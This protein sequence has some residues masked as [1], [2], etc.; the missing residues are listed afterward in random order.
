[1]NGMSHNRVW[2]NL[3]NSTIA[4]DPENLTLKGMQPAPP[5]IYPYHPNLFS[6]LLSCQGNQ[7]PQ[8]QFIDLMKSVM[9]D[10]TLTCS[11]LEEI[12]K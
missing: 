4:K 8:N 12:V 1:M 10:A 7:Q 11:I 5:K 6:N 2:H 9:T 3:D